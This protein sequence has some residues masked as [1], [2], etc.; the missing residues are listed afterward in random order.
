MTDHPVWTVDLLVESLVQHQKRTRG[1]CAHSL[2]QL[3]RDLN[4]FLRFALG[5]DPITPD[6]L[7]AR[8]VNEFITARAAHFKPRTVKVTATSLRWLFRFLRLEG[9]STA[10]ALEEAVPTVAQ[11]RLSGLPRG[12]E[13]R[14]LARLLD[15]LDGSTAI[16]LR[17]RAIIILLASLGLRAGELADLQL[18][19]L[20]WRAGTVSIRRRKAGHGALLPL[21]PDAGQAI[22]AYLQQGRP[23]TADRHVFVVQKGLQDR[24]GAG[25]SGAVVAGIVQRALLRAGVVVPCCG[26]HALRHSL[27]TRMVQH[28]ARLDE[29]ANVLGHRSL[30]S[31]AIYAKVDLP[32]LREVPLPWPEVRP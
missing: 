29:I 31:T 24:I 11:W 23:K 10:R 17:D 9:I 18:E 4:D 5:P 2:R 21:P 3:S 19:D 16:G 28:G 30:E 20:D 26:A 8:H 25:F 7:T 14:D 6:Q 15:S 22:V 13:D 32:M 1:T 27:A 12:L